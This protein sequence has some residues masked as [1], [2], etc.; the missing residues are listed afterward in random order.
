M[1][2]EMLNIAG[3]SDMFFW[4]LVQEVK[5]FAQL[6]AVP[7]HCVPSSGKNSPKTTYIFQHSNTF[8]TLLSMQDRPFIKCIFPVFSGISAFIS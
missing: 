8:S 6:M 5:D 4:A 2:P 1:L 7:V 3:S